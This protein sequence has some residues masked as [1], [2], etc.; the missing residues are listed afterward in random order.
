MTKGK[1]ELLAADVCTKLALIERH[2]LEHKMRVPN[3]NL[4]PFEEEKCQVVL[5]ALSEA[6]D[7]ARQPLSL[8]EMSVADLHSI[9][10]NLHQILKWARRN[11]RGMS[12]SKTSQSFGTTT[13]IHI[14]KKGAD[15]SFSSQPADA[16][17]GRSSGPPLR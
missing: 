1:L 7:L 4:D 6:H 5:D 8:E 16:V 10:S 15:V 13:M 17:T 14:G 9:E 11:A 3:G 2:I 12:R